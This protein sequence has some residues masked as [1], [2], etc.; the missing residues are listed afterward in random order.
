MK[1]Y[2]YVTWNIPTI[3]FLLDSIFCL[4]MAY[5]KSNR[6]VLSIIYGLFSVE[7]K[8]LQRFPAR[9]HDWAELNFT[10]VL[11]AA[12]TLVDP[13][14]IKKIDNLTVF[15]MLLGSAHVKAVRRT[16]M[17]LSPC[18]RAIPNLNKSFNLFRDKLFKK[19]H[20][21]AVTN[22]KKDGEILIYWYRID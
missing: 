17:K 4:K 1:K 15:F 2:C 10:N 12:F 11:R 7:N 14:S 3:F 8:L 13:K 6:Q 18:S 22:Q 19:L 9:C 16:L 21:K 5:S 20:T